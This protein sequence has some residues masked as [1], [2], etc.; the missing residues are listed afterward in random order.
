M[1][2]TPDGDETECIVVIV[3]LKSPTILVF[4]RGVDFLK[5][6]H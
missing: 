2:F 4:V 6:R 1:D 3:V 5:G